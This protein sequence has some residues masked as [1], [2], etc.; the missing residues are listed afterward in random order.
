MSKNNLKESFVVV[1]RDDK[2]NGKHSVLF[3]KYSILSDDPLLASSFSTLDFFFDI[4]TDNSSV[5]LDVKQR[6]R[7]LE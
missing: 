2:E 7:T 6:L 4:F 5:T 3:L 1:K